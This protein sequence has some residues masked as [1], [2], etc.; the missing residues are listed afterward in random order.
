VERR[1]NRLRVRV[2]AAPVD[3]AANR[4]VIGLLAE[5]LRIAPSRIELV[6]GATSRNKVFRV[7]APHPA[8]SP[9]GRGSR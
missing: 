5:T 6:R 3:G 8:L 7:A 9:E 4:A 2:M 1:G